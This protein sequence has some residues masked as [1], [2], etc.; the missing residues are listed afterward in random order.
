M[1]RL[2]YLIHLAVVSI[3]IVLIAVPPAAACRLLKGRCCVCCCVPT[4]EPASCSESVQP[5][6]PGEMA[7]PAEASPSDAPPAATTQASEPLTPIATALP[8]EVALPQAAPEATSAPV[9]SPPAVLTFG[10][11]PAPAPS[12]PAARPH[13]ITE[14]PAVAQSADPFS[15][16]ATTASPPQVNSAAALPADN[17]SPPTI[18]D[19]PGLEPAPQTLTPRQ[20]VAAPATTATNNPP[21]SPAAI[22]PPVTVKRPLATP[23][24]EPEVA[25][26]N[27]PRAVRAPEVPP[28]AHVTPPAFP[29]ASDD[30][31]AP[32]APPKSPAPA[33]DDPFAPL[34][35]AA[36][37]KPSAPIAAEPTTIKVADALLPGTDGRLP[38]REWRD[39]S[40]QFN[41]KAR[42]VLILDEKVRLLKETGRTTTV[43]LS[44]LSATDRAYIDE[45]VSRY[46]KDLL[47]LDK[48]AAR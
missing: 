26:G 35:P 4:C 18:T 27:L 42:L 28:T 47:G 22:A 33:E 31:F 29:K 30:P 20:G 37:P 8:A 40:G 15:R 39:D 48:L 1:K 6:A 43:S 19:S 32:I 36:T 23:M 9:D 21:H 10:E 41:V 2:L 24:P 25:A 14:P 16:P 3:S 34:P 11:S 44:R 45:I 7:P 17:S 46:G 5:S 12:S 13:T 38:I